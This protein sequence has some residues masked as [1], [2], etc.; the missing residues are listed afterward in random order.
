MYS[1]LHPFYEVAISEIV[2]CTDRRLNIILPF[3]AF[4]DRDLLSE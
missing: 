4:V 1:S 2:L 3:K